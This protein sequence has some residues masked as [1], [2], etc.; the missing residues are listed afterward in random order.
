VPSCERYAEME[1]R[2]FRRKS[3]ARVKHSTGALRRPPGFAQEIIQ[4]HP[5]RV[6]QPFAS[7]FP[8]IDLA[9]PLTTPFAQIVLQRISFYWCAPAPA[10]EFQ[11]E[12]LGG[13]GGVGDDVEGALADEAGVGPQ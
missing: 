1:W 13:E 7:E 3:I 2:I 9:L 6:A 5:R 10:P 12:E 4:N 8:A 11:L